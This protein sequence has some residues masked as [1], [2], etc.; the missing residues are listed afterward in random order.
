MKRQ[1][2][3]HYLHNIYWSDQINVKATT[4]EIPYSQ[5][6]HL[7]VCPMNVFKVKQHKY[8]YI[9]YDI[10]VKKKKINAFLNHAICRRSTNR[11][12][13]ITRARLINKS[14]TNIVGSWKAQTLLFPF[15]SVLFYSVHST[16]VLYKANFIYQHI[17]SEISQ[18]FFYV[19]IFHDD[20]LNWK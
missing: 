3:K 6:K 16:Y 11:P 9:Y 13:K 14:N 2:I 12:I 4:K 15:A 10:N 8:S 20:S 7:F 5:S 19:F 17:F 18:I 1:P